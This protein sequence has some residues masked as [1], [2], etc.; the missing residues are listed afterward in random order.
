MLNH[1]IFI[2]KSKNPPT[3]TSNKISDG[4]WVDIFNSAFQFS[5][6]KEPQFYHKSKLVVGV[7]FMP[8]KKVFGT[9]NW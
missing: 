5:N 7:E 9:D 6:D 2:L 4:R 1:T 3:N 8:Y